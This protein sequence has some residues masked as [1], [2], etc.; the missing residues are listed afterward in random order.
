[1][2]DRLTLYVGRLPL[3][4]GHRDGRGHYHGPGKPLFRYVTAPGAEP[5][6]TGYVR[7]ASSAEVRA[8]LRDRFPDREL[9]FQPIGS[10]PRSGSS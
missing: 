7:G 10:L 9:D 4:H 3:D 5:V 6:S 8:A 2:T 1:M